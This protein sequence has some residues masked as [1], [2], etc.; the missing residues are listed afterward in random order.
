MDLDEL[1]FV[2]SLAASTST[3]WQIYPVFLYA[4]VVMKCV[5]SIFLC[6]CCLVLL[7]D[8]SLGE[9]S[10]GDCASELMIAFSSSEGSRVLCFACMLML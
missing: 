3:T 1:A 7:N 2:I 6:S 9:D 10:T 4:Q 8:K 5:K